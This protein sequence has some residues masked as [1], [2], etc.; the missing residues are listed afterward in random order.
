MLYVQI[1]FSLEIDFDML[2]FESKEQWTINKV[3]NWNCKMTLNFGNKI[4]VIPLVW[5]IE[6]LVL[7]LILLK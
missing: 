2:G 1:K 3:N 4:L 7:V 6:N 5:V